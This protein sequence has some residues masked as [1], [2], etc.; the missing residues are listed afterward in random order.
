MGTKKGFTPLFS[1]STIRRAKTTAL[2]GVP[3][4][5]E[6]GMNLIKGVIRYLEMPNV[7]TR[8]TLPLLYEEYGNRMYHRVSM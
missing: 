7:T 2:D 5:T 1:P 8:L 4:G 6:G 3:L